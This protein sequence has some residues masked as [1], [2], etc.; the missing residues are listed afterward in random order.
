MRQTNENGKKLR[1]GTTNETNKIARR[2]M[3]IATQVF[4]GRTVVLS[5]DQ[6]VHAP[7]SKHVEEVPGRRAHPQ[8]KQTNKQTW[9]TGQP[10]IVL[11]LLSPVIQLTGGL[12]D[13][14]LRRKEETKEQ[15]EMKRRGQ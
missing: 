1:Q 11:L 7:Q 8:N 14:S 10:A 3:R 4:F 15:R 13:Y 5:Q 2:E 9:V 6:A 12:Y